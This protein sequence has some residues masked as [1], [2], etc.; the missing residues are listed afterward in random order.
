M[1]TGN[2]LGGWP[3]WAKLNNLPSYYAYLG[4]LLEKISLGMPS[5]VYHTISKT[6][7]QDI[8]DVKPNARIKVVYPGIDIEAYGNH[9]DIE[10]DDFILFIGRLVFYKNLDLLIEAFQHVIKAATQCETCYRG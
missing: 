2:K 9:N 6:T 7:M 8:I 4:K 3:R 10:Y 1:Y 5:D